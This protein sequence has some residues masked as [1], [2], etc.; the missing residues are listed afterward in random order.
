MQ[1]AFGTSEESSNKVLF[2]SR[3][4]DYKTPFGGVHTRETVS[5]RFPV[6]EYMHAESVT[7]LLRRNEHIIKFPLRFDKKADGYEIFRLDFS[8]ER[9][10]TY[11]YRFE[12]HTDFGETINVGRERG[13]QAVCGDWLPEWTLSV[14]EN[15]YSTPDCFKG[16]I[17]YHIFCDRFCHEG[18]TVIPNYG[19]LKNWDED[20]T[21]VDPD[22]VYRANDFYGGNFQGIISKLDYLAE[23]GVTA[24]YLSPIFESSSNHRYDTGDYNKIDKLLG[25]EADFKELIEKAKAKGIGIVLDGVFNHT[26]ADSVYFNKFNHYDSLGA[27]QSKESPY[28]DWFTFYD[29]PDDYHCWWGITVVPTVA[30]DA[31]GFHELIAGKDGIIKK[32]TDMGVAGWRLDVVDELSGNFVKYIRE[33][34]K[35]E[36]RDCVIIGEVWEDASTKYSYGEER[37]YFRGAELDGVMNYV[38]KDAIMSFLSGG[39]GADFAETVM[40]IIENY[41]KCSLDCCMTLIDSH[42]TVRAINALSGVKTEGTDKEYRKNYR[43]N[44]EE[45]HHGKDL[46]KLAVALQYFLPGVPSVYYGDE[47]GMQ[48][49][50]DPINRRPFRWNSVDTEILEHYKYFGKLRKEHREKFLEPALVYGNG[51]TV[52]II[53]NSVKLTVNRDSLEIKVELD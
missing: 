31:R 2:N 28:Y 20:V 40:E 6:A 51:N 39:D 50:E 42:D 45:Y 21:I 13:G 18:E 23:L 35:R 17:V 1:N 33:R 37:E 14:S 27:Y 32:W 47:I 49:F 16:G 26:G 22:G 38:F 3:I 30:R 44:H 48:G 12:I 10:G 15:G 5:I 9:D 4:G 43:L 25:S 53:R 19:V 46:L 29:Y 36:N 24:I 11:Y 52:K 41:P 34:V 7:M 8:V